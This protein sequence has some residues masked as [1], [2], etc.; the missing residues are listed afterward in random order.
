MSESKSTLDLVQTALDRIGLEALTGAGEN[1]VF[2]PLSAVLSLGILLFI[3]D[4]ELYEPILGWCG[5][6]LET[7]DEDFADVLKLLA[8]GFEAGRGTAMYWQYAVDEDVDVSDRGRRC[9]ERA[10]SSVLVTK[11]PSPGAEVVNRIVRQ[12]TH[13]LIPEAISDESSRFHTQFIVN[14]IYLKRFWAHPLTLREIFDWELPDSSEKTV[15]IGETGRF[16]YAS[17]DSFHYLA[18]PYKEDTGSEMEIFMTLSRSELP[19]GLTVDEMNSLREKAETNEM[20]I[21]IPKWEDTVKTDIK[22]LFNR[23]G[24]DVDFSDLES[25]LIEQ[26][27]FIK[28]DEY[29]TEACAVTDVGCIEDVDLRPKDFVVNRPFIYTI[30]TKN[31]TEFMGYFYKPPRPQWPSGNVA[32]ICRELSGAPK[33]KENLST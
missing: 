20:K 23:I 8:Q 18:L 33:S 14:V 11:F 26:K 2:S 17:D 15:L 27:A 16:K 30:R 9:I 13:L 7:S 29:G 25:I 22:E 32:R 4:R 5:L 21:F 10:G 31:V 3:R 6:S 19:F 12:V 28:V 1:R 24:F